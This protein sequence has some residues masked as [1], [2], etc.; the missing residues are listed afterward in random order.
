MV[1]LDR[2]L[3]CLQCG[4]LSISLKLLQELLGLKIDAH[5]VRHHDFAFHQL[6]GRY[7][8]VT[9]VIDLRF[10][11]AHVSIV[12]RIGAGELPLK[13]ESPPIQGNQ[14][15]RFPSGSL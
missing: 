3:Q 7:N 2:F 9:K 5:R 13:Q 14:P 10:C 4:L 6:V 1:Q 8:V 15:N 11:R 12:G